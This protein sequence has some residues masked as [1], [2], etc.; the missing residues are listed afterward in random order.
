[1]EA[2]NPCLQYESLDSG[3]FD[4]FQR[5]RFSRVSSKLSHFDRDGNSR[6]SRRGPCHPP[7]FHDFF[8]RIPFF[9]DRIPR[10]ERELPRFQL[11]E[12]GMIRRSEIIVFFSRIFRKFLYLET[13]G[14]DGSL[15]QREAKNSENGETCH[16]DHFSKK[17]FRKRLER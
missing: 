7:I 15:S 17:V 9:D 8:P 16:V 12:L 5:R 4:R 6:N 2:H 1:M 10:F 11:H 13:G 3:P 14:S